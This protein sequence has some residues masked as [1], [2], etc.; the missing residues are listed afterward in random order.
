MEDII[1]SQIVSTSVTCFSQQTISASAPGTPFPV[2]QTGIDPIVSTSSYVDSHGPPAYTSGRSPSGNYG[3]ISRQESS[4]VLNSP[5]SAPNTPLHP[6]GNL[7]AQQRN[8]TPS[9]LSPGSGM[10]WRSPAHQQFYNSG[11][12]LRPG[13]NPREPLAMQNRYPH[14]ASSQPMRQQAQPPAA[15]TMA[16]PQGPANG[17]MQR[18]Y[19]PQT[20]YIG[21]AAQSGMMMMETGAG[22]TATSGQQQMFVS[23]PMI[24]G[25]GH[26]LSQS[27]PMSGPPNMPVPTPTPATTNTVEEPS[28]QGGNKRINYKKWA[29]DEQLGDHASIAS[30]L[31]ANISCP[32]LKIN[33]PDFP[34]RTKEIQKIWRRLSVEERNK[35][36]VSRINQQWKITHAYSTHFY[37]K[38]ANGP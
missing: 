21:E 18:A 34:Q 20:G 11:Q 17:M 24:S 22:T 33:F 26:A 29:E 38:L 19:A 27:G 2:G 28:I 16:R 32:E 6:G 5:L 8:I 37:L 1:N 36:V 3:M 13:M 4:Q 31:Y 14:P 30:I 25:S 7:A 12:Q 15:G 23:S 35:W 9:V 10:Q